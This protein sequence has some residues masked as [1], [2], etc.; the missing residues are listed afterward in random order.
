M[1]L[2]LSPCQPNHTIVHTYK[3][4][5]H[6]RNNCSYVDMHLKYTIASTPGRPLDMTGGKA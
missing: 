5:D 3:F 2:I 1:T 4:D 6:Y